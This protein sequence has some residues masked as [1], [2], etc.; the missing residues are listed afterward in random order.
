MRYYLV[1]GEASGDLHGANLMKALKAQDPHAEFRYF[2][3]DKMRAEGG[4]LAKH[5]A[6]MAFMGFTEVLLNLRTILRNLKTCK[7]D[8]QAYAPDVLILIDFPGFNL[9][10][11]GFGKESGIKVCYYISPKV[12]AWNQKRVIKIKKVV[13]RMFCILPFEVG[14][15]KEWGMKVDYVG[16]PLLDEKASFVPDPAFC[17]QQGLSSAH[18]IIA[19]LPGSRKQEIER[20]LPAMLSVTEQFPD[21]QFVIAAAPGFPVV[22]YQQFIGAKN[23]K[24]VFGKT[25]DLLNVATAAIVASGTAT[26]ETALFHVPQVV[27]YKG[28]A[29]SIAIARM[30]VKIRFISLVNL[31]MDKEVVVELIQQDCNTLNITDN[32]SRL[33]EGPWREVMLEN[34]ADLSVVMGEPGASARTASLISDYLKSQS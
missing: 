28:G 1:A 5:Y 30:L 26:L 9:K 6:D 2:G 33:I 7:D 18:Q 16:N 20:L 32:L 22:Y 24:L 23:V 11:A 27:V 14:F 8:I 13:D 10:I 12:W 31:I 25:Y 15:Y 21:Q 29:I 34:Y 4:M 19:L 3:G 17:D